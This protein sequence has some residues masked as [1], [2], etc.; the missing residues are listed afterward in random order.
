MKKILVIDDEKPIQSLLK[1]YFSREGFEV[2][3]E[4]NGFNGIER[5]KQESFDAIICDVKLPDLDGVD[6]LNE[7]RKIN[8][9]VE[10]IMAT[11]MGS[12]EV[13]LKSIHAGAFDFIGKPFNLDEMLLIVKKAIR[14]YESKKMIQLLNDGLKDAYIELEKAKESLEMNVRQRTKEL[15]LSEKKYRSI[16]NDAFDPIITLN[17]RMEITSWNKGAEYALGYREADLLGKSLDFLIAEG[18]SGLKNE[19]I[20][21][22]FIRNYISQW[23]KG[24][25]ETIYVNITASL[26]EGGE[27]SVIVR[28]IT[29][30]KMVDQMKTDFVSNV[31]HELRTP[32]TSIKGAV[33]LILGGTEGVVSEGQN[34]LLTIVRKNTL[35]LIK[36]INDLLDLSKI[37]AGKIEME[38]RRGSLLV[39]LDETIKE[40]QILAENKKIALR[41]EVAGTLPDAMFDRDRIKQVLI[42]LT[43]NALKF[44]PENGFITVL[45]KEEGGEI[46]VAVTDSGMG[47]SKENFQKLFGR[48]QQVDSSS[49]R[50]Q[51]G[52]GLGLAISKS[53]IEAH[54]GRIWVDS[55]YGKGSTFSF[56]LPKLDG[57]VVSAMPAAVAPA[58]R[59]VPFSGQVYQVRRILVVD[60]DEDIARI[61]RGHLE[62]QGYEVAVVHSGIEVM[63][64]ALEYKPHLITLDEVMPL[65]D[66]YS[67]AEL[68]KQ[69]PATRDIPIVMVSVAFEKEKGYR[70]GVADYI[71]KPFEPAELYDP[72]RRVEQQAQNEREKKKVLIVDDDPDIIALLTLAMHEKKYSVLNAYDGLQAVSLAQKEKPDIILLDLMLPKFDGFQVIKMLKEDEATKEIPIIVITA[73]NVEDAARV[74]ELGARQ[75]LIKPFAI[76]TLVDEIGKIVKKES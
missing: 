10:V 28:D 16:I 8:A 7:I 19:F 15:V 63:K 73:R 3:T 48:F 61:I 57:T 44:T 68:L 31:S 59:D 23:K 2:Q 9:D 45:A 67:I 46:V 24:S 47:I 40:M 34:E 71:T 52:T 1:K 35:R 4:D 55:E 37:E 33:E 53:I 38:M 54:K 30:E 22:G 13:A 27:I 58:G 20:K 36:M 65:I 69:N 17:D 42:N 18:H 29:R 25:G 60:E 32:L 11:G 39:P 76:R 43:S 75:Y 62:K 12:F 66:G 64:K 72:I 49:T 6:V 26:I 51:G 21:N 41:L 74:M 5:L 56:A 70:L 50:A 14:S